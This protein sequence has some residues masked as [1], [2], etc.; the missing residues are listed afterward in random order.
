MS[1]SFA[2]RQAADRRGIVLRSLDE[3][4]HRLPES[5][6]RRVLDLHGHRISMGELHADLEFLERSLLV[7]IDREPLPSGTVWIVQ[8]L[9]EGQVVARGRSHPGIGG[10]D[11]APV[12]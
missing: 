9:D 11:Y 10:A 5:S 12:R 2:E 1:P 4:G 6:L 8:L 3:G 7:R